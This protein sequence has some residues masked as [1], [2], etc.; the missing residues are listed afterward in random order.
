MSSLTCVSV[1]FDKA[2]AKLRRL[3]YGPI[4]PYVGAWQEEL[5]C[6]YIVQEPENNVPCVVSVSGAMFSTYYVVMLDKQLQPVWFRRPNGGGT[7]HLLPGPPEIAASLRYNIAI[8]HPL[9]RP[10]EVG[11]WYFVNGY[12]FN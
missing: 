5:A 7:A 9:G 11:E 2:L 8:W 3:A 10:P 4:S 12:H 6:F 1:P